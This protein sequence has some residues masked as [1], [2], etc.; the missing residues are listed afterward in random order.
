[1]TKSSELCTVVEQPVFLLN[2]ILYYP[3]YSNPCWV[4][5]GAFIIEANKMSK[6]KDYKED[7]SKHFSSTELFKR[8]AKLIPMNLWERSWTSNWRNWLKP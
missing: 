6:L 8:N 7:K 5:P 2:N 4:A 1:M 3:H